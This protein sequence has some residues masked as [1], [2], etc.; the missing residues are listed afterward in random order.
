MSEKQLCY[1][2]MISEYRIVFRLS[3]FFFCHVGLIFC[4]PYIETFYVLA[5]SSIIPKRIRSPSNTSS[6]KVKQ[7]ISRKILVRF[8]RIYTRCRWHALPTT[9]FSPFYTHFSIVFEYY[10]CCSHWKASMFWLL[11]SLYYL[12]WDHDPWLYMLLTLRASLLCRAM[13]LQWARDFSSIKN[14]CFQ[15]RSNHCGL[16][17]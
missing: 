17:D 13:L 6:T 14:I 10:C 16:I 9:D 4:S 2:E 8:K 7:P 15:V 5:D 11:C 3:W 1:I 12:T